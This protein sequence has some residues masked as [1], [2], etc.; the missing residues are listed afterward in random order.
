MMDNPVF[1]IIYPGNDLHSC[2]LYHY[3]RHVQRNRN[4]HCLHWPAVALFHPKLTSVI[5]LCIAIRLLTISSSCF[6][7]AFL[8]LYYMIFCSA[9][10]KAGL[11]GGSL[12]HCYHG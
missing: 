9:A 1:F 4:W 8:D 12:C 2:C 6:S 7:N 10:S 3:C 11:P 5:I